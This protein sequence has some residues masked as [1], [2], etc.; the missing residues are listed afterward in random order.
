[1]QNRNR[2][3]KGQ[4]CCKIRAGGK[5]VANF[6][7]QNKSRRQ[8]YK[9][10]NVSARLQNWRYCMNQGG[11]FFAVGTYWN[12]RDRTSCNLF[13]LLYTA[14]IS[15]LHQSELIFVTDITDYICGEKVVM[16]RNFSF[17]CMTIVGKLKISPHVEKF[18]TIDGVLLQ[19]MP[20]CC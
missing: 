18:N 17:P 5:I 10:K 3:T 15:F 13:P 16:W 20:F 4:D 12:E 11:A 14:G 1:M 6:W 19:L 7:M 8:G 2:R 9:A